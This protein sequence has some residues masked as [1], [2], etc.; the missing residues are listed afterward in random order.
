M[1]I[2]VGTTACDFLKGA[3]QGLR[4]Q[5][6]T[7]STPGVDGQFALRLGFNEGEFSFTAI[8]FDTEAN[9]IT[10]KTALEALQGTVV[11]I[12]DDQ[13]QVWPN[14]LISEVLAA[15]RWRSAARGTSA[16]VGPYD[17]RGEILVK[18]V[19]TLGN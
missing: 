5:V 14:C 12:T 17:T 2:Q 18:G 13:G 16:R 7:W 15:P 9:A 19:V 4:Q 1:P 3:A 6:M 11:S 8:L 10:W